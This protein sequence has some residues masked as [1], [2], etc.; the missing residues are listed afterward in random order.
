MILN[1]PDE[2]E[3]IQ[4]LA[5][6]FDEPLISEWKYQKVLDLFRHYEMRVEKVE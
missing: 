3:F 4:E 1:L 6:L 2:D 5:D